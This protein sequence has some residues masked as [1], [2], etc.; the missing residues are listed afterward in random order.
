MQKVELTIKLNGEIKQYQQERAS[1]KPSRSKRQNKNRVSLV[2][3]TNHKEP[4]KKTK[5]V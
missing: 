4:N 5:E 3:Q 2:S 1:S